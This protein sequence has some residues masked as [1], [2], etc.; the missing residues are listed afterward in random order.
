MAQDVAINWL[1]TLGVVA[2]SAIV[3]FLCID[4]FLKV[5][6][7]IG[8]LPFVIYRFILGGLLLWFYL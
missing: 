6:A 1:L 8:M 7:K 5:V 3:A 2:C 4:W